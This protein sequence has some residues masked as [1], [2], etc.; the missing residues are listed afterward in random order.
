ME[1]FYC[2]VCGWKGDE[3]E[4][5][6]SLCLDKLGQMRAVCPNGCKDEKGRQVNVYRNM[7]N[8]ENQEFFVVTIGGKFTNSN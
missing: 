2:D 8:V 6:P 7:C 5:A 3:V 1:K 4:Y